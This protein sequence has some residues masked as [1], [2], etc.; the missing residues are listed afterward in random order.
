VDPDDCLAIW[1]LAA[2]RV[3]ERHD[4]LGLSVSFGNLGQGA[5]LATLLDLRASLGGAVLPDPVRGVARG[6]WASGYEINLP[7]VRRICR[8][9]AN[10]RLTLLAL[11]PLSLPAAVVDH[12]P[13]PAQARLTL[14]A[15]AGRRSGHVF[16]PAED[17]ASDAWLRH[18][19]VF[20]DFNVKSDVHAAGRVVESGVRLVLLPYEM[21]REFEVDAE[22]VAGLGRRPDGRWLAPRL[23]PWL[24]HWNRAMGRDGFYPFDLMAALYLADP[25]AFDC[26]AIPVSFARDPLIGWFGGPPSL[27]IAPGTPTT[28]SRTRVCLHLRDGG[29]QK[30]RAWMTS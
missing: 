4:W 6:R 15:V 24:A 16:H 7:V 5:G 1:A 26:R 20:S 27:L 18:G 28:G 17:R 9:L 21:A 30:L 10:E 3:V 12:C 25:G 8:H 11:G 2:H 22:L 13:K 19:P 29:R 23:R 14:V